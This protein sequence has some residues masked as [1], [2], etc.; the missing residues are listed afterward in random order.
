MV[1]IWS[2]E[3]ARSHSVRAEANSALV[4]GTLVQIS[5]DGV[6]P[7]LPLSQIQ[8]ADLDGWTGDLQ[9]PGWRKIA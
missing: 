9:A 4:A 7:P 1:V 3:A 8:R 5:I 2:P 6:A